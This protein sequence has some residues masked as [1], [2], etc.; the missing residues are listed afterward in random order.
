MDQVY[1][2]NS[3]CFKKFKRNV[4]REDNVME[5]EDEDDENNNEITEN[6]KFDDPFFSD[7]LRGSRSSHW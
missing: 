7:S 4:L 6:I 3:E 2:R 1:Y 5:K